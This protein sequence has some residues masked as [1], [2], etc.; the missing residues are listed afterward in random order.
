D[1]RTRLAAAANLV[2]A[3]LNNA[4]ALCIQNPSDPVRFVLGEK[5]RS[6]FLAYESEP[7]EPF[8]LPDAIGGAYQIVF[9]EG[10]HTNLWDVALRP[11]GVAED[12]IDSANAPYVTF[13][14]FGRLV[15]PTEVRL[16]V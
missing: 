2:V 10:D 5:G 11:E 12:S 4:R 8:E 9:G 1:E 7:S 13:D 15:P 14:A 3:D 16:E 6:Y